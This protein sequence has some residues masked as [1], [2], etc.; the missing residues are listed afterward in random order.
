MSTKDR[1]R[2]ARSVSI[3]GPGRLG[4]ALAISLSRCG[5]TIKALVARRPKKAGKLA[6]SLGTHRDKI[7]VLSLAE[8]STLEPT[9]LILITTPDDAIESVVQKLATSMAGGSGRQVVLHTSGALS[10]EVLSSL[11][12]IGFHTGSLHPLVS[13]SEPTAGAKAL[14]GAFFCIE[15]DAQ[16]T[17]M[18][19]KIVSDLGGKHFTV[20]ARN[21]PLYHAAALTAAGHMTALIDLAIEMLVS[22]GLKRKH[23]QQVL[24]PLVQS[25]VKNLNSSTPAQALTG[26]FARGDLATVQRHLDALSGTTQ[27]EA[28]E[29]YKILGLH[30]LRLAGKT[31][32]PRVAQQIKEFA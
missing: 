2:S 31:I 16:A 12:G 15:G 19:R 27:A 18:A 9:N 17:R 32:D 8:L 5:Y 13:V 21:K 28:L 6:D 29:V 20:E 22:S 14:R 23:A 11:V 1:H 24:M 25:A 4:Q 26:T 10:S 7:R 3:I 30:S